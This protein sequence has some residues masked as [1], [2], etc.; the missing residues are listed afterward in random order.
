MHTPPRHGKVKRASPVG[1]AAVPLAPPVRVF[2]QL[3]ARLPAE[4]AG[5]LRAFSVR[6]GQSLNAIVASALE[7][8]LDQEDSS[9]PA[10]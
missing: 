9:R 6:S 3:G 2:S 7:R 10:E 4:L 8:F 5:R 1:A